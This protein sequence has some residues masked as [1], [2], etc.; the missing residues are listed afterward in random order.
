M[1]KQIRPSE[2]AEIVTGLLVRP[3]L[4]GELDG[5]SQVH[6]EFIEAIGQVVADFCGGS[7]HCVRPADLPL[8]HTPDFVE[9]AY[10]SILPNS[11]LPSL[12]NCVW[13]PY[14]P[15]GWEGYTNADFDLGDG[16]AQSADDI[17]LLRERLQ[18]LLTE[19]VGA[20]QAQREREQEAVADEAMSPTEKHA[21]DTY[22][23]A[24]KYLSALAA[25]NL[26]FHFEDDPADCLSAHNLTNEQIEAI[27]HNVAQ[28]FAIDWTQ[29]GYECPF[30]Y[31]TENH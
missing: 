7:V 18:G 24:C 29:G 10:L 4:L 23:T 8:D 14:D 27:S 25:A 9:T 19:A 16:T 12:E 11:S 20:Q 15:E 1:S 26:L 21:I 6:E 30:D 5:S 13:A 3:D 28:L 22:E 31:I 2:L 17:N